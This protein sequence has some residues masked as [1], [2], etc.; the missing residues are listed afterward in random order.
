MAMTEDKMPDT[1]IKALGNNKLGDI[2]V[3]FSFSTNSFTQ[4]EETQVV[5]MTQKYT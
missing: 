4:L 5:T 2:M 1:Y 3:T